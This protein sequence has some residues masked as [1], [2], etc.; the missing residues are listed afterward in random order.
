[1]SNGTPSTIIRGWLDPSIVFAPL[2][3]MVLPAPGSPF[4]LDILT[5]EAFPLSA[6]TTVGSPDLNTDWVF[7]IEEVD[8]CWS[9]TTV[10]PKEVTITS[11]NSLLG[12]KETVIKSWLLTVTFW[13]V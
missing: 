13:L 8:P 4:V 7:T 11:S 5:P 2:I 9:F 3:L 1:M 10:K 6:L 12:S